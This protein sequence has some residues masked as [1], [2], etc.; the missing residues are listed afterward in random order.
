M[1]GT[2]NAMVGSILGVWGGNSSTLGPG[3]CDPTEHKGYSGK[4][5]MRQRG[6][7]KIV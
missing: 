6:L 1:G 7:W 5:C 3:P 4:L 2:L